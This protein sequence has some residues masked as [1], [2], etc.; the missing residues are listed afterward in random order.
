[1]A[2]PRIQATY[3][4]SEDSPDYVLGQTYTFQLDGNQILREDPDG[5][6]EVGALASFENDWADVVW[7]QHMEVVE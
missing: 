4:G 7:L 6:T 5:L 3:K 1:M 2:N